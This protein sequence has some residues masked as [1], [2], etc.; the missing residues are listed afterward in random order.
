LPLR[1]LNRVKAP[2]QEEEE[3]ATRRPGKGVSIAGSININRNSPRAS[4]RDSEKV[5][6]KEQKR[7]ALWAAD[8]DRFVIFA[9]C[10]DT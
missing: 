2:P 1:E 10:R 4:H 7:E 3:K 9:A 8:K 6:L 5:S